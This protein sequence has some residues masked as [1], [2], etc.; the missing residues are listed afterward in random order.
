MEL[1]AER[2]EAQDWDEAMEIVYQRGWTDGLPVVIPTET[3]V[4]KMLEGVG[5]SPLDVIG[6]IPPRNG[7]ATL[8]KIAIN[9]VMAGCLPEYLPVVVSAIQAMLDESFN[10]NGVQTTTHCVA[11][12]CIV[13]GPVVKELAFNCE[14]G[15]FGGGSRA[16]ATVG[17]AIRLI[18]WNIGGA[19]PGKL[20]RATL[21]HP[22][23]YTY[24]IAENQ[25]A[26][27]WEPL[28]V[29]RGLRP[30]QSAATVFGCEAPHHVRTG[31][32]G[33]GFATL[34]CIADSMS[35]LG[36][37]VIYGGGQMLVVVGPRAAMTLANEGW[38]KREVKEFIFENARKPASKLKRV[39]AATSDEI[40]GAPRWP[41]WLDPADDEAMFPVMRKPEDIHITVAGGWGAGLA[42][43][44]I[45]PGWGVHGGHAQTRAVIPL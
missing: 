24:C 9:C 13:S 43:C 16:N 41:K 20:D 2:V 35:T 14:D 17:R 15:V 26:N 38:T 40:G 33:T 1:R 34:T 21:G 39:A 10:L 22:G 11:P 23:K 7:I 29:E 31:P 4:V 18:L 3:K 6:K 25:D 19:F 36:S 28:H 5:R 32:A 8:E 42:F 44:A 27:P 12:L 45:C 37:N 30:E